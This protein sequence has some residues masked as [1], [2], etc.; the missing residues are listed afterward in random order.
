[1]TWQLSFDIVRE[2]ESKNLEGGLWHNH[3]IDRN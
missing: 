2:S 1:M 3:F